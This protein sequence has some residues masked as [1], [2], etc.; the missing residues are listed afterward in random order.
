M[1][2]LV[3]ATTTTE[4][5]KRLAEVAGKLA[6]KALGERSIFDARLGRRLSVPMFER[7]HLTPG[8]A[9]VGP[10][11]VVEAGTSTYVSPSFDL[12]VDSGG[13]LVLTARPD[14]P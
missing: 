10:A 9:L 5:P 4:P 7:E 2:W 11:L 3:L 1:S 8:T 6:P 13:A 14:A 12:S